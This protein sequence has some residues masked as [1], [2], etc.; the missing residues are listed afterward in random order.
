MRTDESVVSLPKE[1]DRVILGISG[2]TKVHSENFLDE[3]FAGPTFSKHLA[4]CSQSYTP[5][6][7]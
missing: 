3:T 6:A 7:W 1:K 4:R 2:G 5:A